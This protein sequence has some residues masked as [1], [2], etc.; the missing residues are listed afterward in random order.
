MVR[1]S[2]EGAQFLFGD[3][4]ILG[5][6]GSIGTETFR[7]Q[8][9]IQPRHILFIENEGE[10]FFMIL[11]N[12]PGAS[13]F[14]GVPIVHGTRQKIISRHTLR[15][16]ALEL[17]IERVSE[18]EKNAPVAESQ[19]AG[20]ASD[21][22]PIGKDLGLL[23]LIVDNIDD[24]IAVVDVQGARIWNNTAYARVL[25][26]S[27]A[28]L[29][30]SDSLIEVHPE[31]LPIV[32]AAFRESMSTGTGRR[33]EYR[34]RH[35]SGHYIYL[36]SQGWVLPESKQREKLLVVISRDITQ[37]K[38][39]ESQQAAQMA[40]A[41]SYVRSQLPANLNES[42]RT[43]WIYLPSATLGGDA[44]DF[45]WLDPEHL[46]IFLLDVVG[47]GVGSALLAISILQLLRQRALNDA[48]LQNPTSVMNALNRS[49]QMDEQGEKV[50]SI[51]YGVFDRESR[52]L[53]YSAGGHPPALLL[54]P[55]KGAKPVAE[56]LQA[57]GLFIGATELANYEE[58][59]VIVPPNATLLVY[60]DGLF[61][62]SVTSGGML[63]MEGF[64]KTLVD[65]YREK[66]LSLKRV[67]EVLNV[68]H[69]SGEFED[70]A[71]ILQVT[72]L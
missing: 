6:D 9:A 65:L 18:A 57:K 25:G 63:G 43:D 15:L 30:G 46:V 38:I 11:R 64:R 45:F 29:V 39:L 3:G 47:H 23:E 37:R 8:K 48:E 36:E 71:S 17:K 13:V 34:L 12:V 31:D 54:A 69:G 21:S 1:I 27:V 26:Y 67:V 28:T 7:R 5:S 20:P 61:E 4:D 70:D 56:W 24:L 72:F 32:R 50:F 16:E 58:R 10:S 51:W 19:P 60:S 49:F 52:E 33:I 42:V 14:D 22:R 40:D 35:R 53:R 2:I 55:G 41:A 66:D 59:S 68:L 44:L 62:L